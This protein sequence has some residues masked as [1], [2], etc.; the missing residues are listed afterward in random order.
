M[1]LAVLVASTCLFWIPAQAGSALIAPQ[2]PQGAVHLVQ[3]NDETEPEDGAAMDSGSDDEDFSAFPKDFVYPRIPVKFPANVEA[4]GLPEFLETLRGI[5]TKRDD[6]A[7]IATVAPKIFWDR[8][9]GGGFD[10][11]VSGVENFRNALQIGIPDILPEYADDGWKRLDGLLASG[12]FSTEDDYPGAYCTPV[13]PDLVDEAAAEPTFKK[14][15]MGDGDWQLQWGYIEGK[16]DGRD[17]PA[18]D[19]AV[20]ATV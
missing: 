13:A 17:K 12:L 1:R 4:P 18:A 14:V 20:V 3:D 5:V 10:E 8:D 11:N 2:P 9:F 15:D 16:A 7:L 19:G 6:A